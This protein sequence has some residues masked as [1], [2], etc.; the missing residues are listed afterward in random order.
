MIQVHSGNILKVKNKD[1]FPQIKNGDA[2]LFMDYFNTFLMVLDNAVNKTTESK[3]CKSAFQITYIFTANYPETWM[4]LES[5]T[6]DYIVFEAHKIIP[7]IE[8]SK[9]IDL[10]LPAHNS[11]KLNALVQ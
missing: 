11:S 1:L 9:S 10:S 8:M 4:D 3:L 7:L 2:F 5:K 6:K